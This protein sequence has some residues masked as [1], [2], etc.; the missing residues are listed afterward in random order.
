M[1]IGRIEVSSYLLGNYSYLSHPYLLK[2]FKPNI[3]DPN[4]SDE[5]KFNESM[6]ARR[7]VIEHAFEAFK[8]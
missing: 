4:F 2:N 8:N 1:K 6:N 3:I 5:R 7:D